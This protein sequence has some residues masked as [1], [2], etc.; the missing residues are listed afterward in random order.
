MNQPGTKRV[1]FLTFITCQQRCL[2]SLL[3]NMSKLGC[4]HTKLTISRKGLRFQY[5]RDD[6]TLFAETNVDNEHFEM[7]QYTANQESL[8]FGVSL[9]S[10]TQCMPPSTKTT[11][12]LRWVFYEN[13]VLEHFLEISIFHSNSGGGGGGGGLLSTASMINV[14][15]NENNDSDVNDD[16]DDNND[17]DTR[18]DKEMKKLKTR[19]KIDEKTYGGGK[20]IVY[21]HHS[22]S[23]KYLTALSKAARTGRIRLGPPQSFNNIIDRITPT[24]HCNVDA[25]VFNNAISAIQKTKISNDVTLTI[26]LAKSELRMHV[27]NARDGREYEEVISDIEITSMSSLASIP[28]SSSSSSSVVL[29]PHRHRSTIVTNTQ[30]FHTRNQSL[31]SSLSSSSTTSIPH[32]LRHVY[33]VGTVTHVAKYRHISK[34]MQ[35]SFNV[36]QINLPLLFCY[37][38]GTLG[39]HQIVMVTV[40]NHDDNKPSPSSSSSS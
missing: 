9:N 36:N 23:K 16:D 33:N 12:Q 1:E 34:S 32:Q 17:N 8:D 30:P 31:P 21:H 22:T 25:E 20:D 28:S 26:D 19:V 5:C 15:S 37:N 38:V 39:Y 35:L 14:N 3:D 18:R 6:R 11:N 13:E 40:T 24:H 2:R 4:S 27:M 29:L 10:V 7:F